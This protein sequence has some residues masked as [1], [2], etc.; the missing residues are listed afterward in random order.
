MSGLS[1]IS[2][3][4][5]LSV[6]KGSYF[7]Y[8]GSEQ[9][10][11]NPNSVVRHRVLLTLMALF[12]LRSY[13][14]KGEKKKKRRNRYRKLCFCKIFFECTLINCLDGLNDQT[15]CI[16]NAD[17]SQHA[18]VVSSIPAFLY[19]YHQKYLF[20]VKTITV[21]RNVPP[22][23]FSQAHNQFNEKRICRIAATA[24]VPLAVES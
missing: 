18:V 17:S 3:R 23:P 16:D 2:R 9:Q 5:V 13:T 4:M 6:W 20:W 7:L 12:C 8:P 24:I 22:G 10:Q 14:Y 11:E 1:S 15:F 19:P 21:F